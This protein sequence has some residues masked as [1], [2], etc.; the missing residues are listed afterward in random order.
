MSSKYFVFSLSTSSLFIS[1]LRVPEEK[2]AVDNFWGWALSGGGVSDNV[3]MWV[4]WH[5]KQRVT[6]D[7]LCNPLQCFS[8]RGIRLWYV[9]RCKNHLQYLKINQHEWQKCEFLLK[10]KVWMSLTHLLMFFHYT[11]F[12]E[13]LVISIIKV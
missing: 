11:T 5:D 12:C 6:L 4:T 7:S 9:P 13:D 8:Q 3:S 1:V 2:L 10:P